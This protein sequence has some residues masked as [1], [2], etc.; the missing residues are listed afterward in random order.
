MPEGC[1]G[2]VLFT[3]EKKLT[4]HLT[5]WLA[6][7]RAYRSQTSGHESLVTPQ[8]DKSGA[9]TKPGKLAIVVGTRQNLQGLAVPDPGVFAERSWTAGQ[10]TV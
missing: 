6:Y 4:G 1:L 7:S 8:C 3:L 10:R 5:G 9:P 2:A